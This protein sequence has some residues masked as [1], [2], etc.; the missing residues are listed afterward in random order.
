[1]AKCCTPEWLG[2]AEAV[3]DRLKVAE[4]DRLSVGEGLRLPVWEPLRLPEGEVLGVGV[5]E[6]LGEPDG[7]GLVAAWP[8]VQPMA[9]A[10]SWGYLRAAMENGWG[11]GW[12]WVWIAPLL[13][14]WLEENGME[15]DKSC[16]HSKRT[17]ICTI[18]T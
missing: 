3:G 4:R 14:L 12:G 15:C 6:G 8:S 1:M 5:K 18:V 10:P 2:D 11:W 17:L 9:G 7:E 16:I 13:L